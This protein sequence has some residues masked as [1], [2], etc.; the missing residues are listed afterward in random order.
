MVLDCMYD[1]Q[2][3]H[4]INS[5]CITNAQTFYDIVTLSKL[6]PPD[7]IRFKTV[8]SA[9][10]NDENDF[11]FVC[12]HMTCAV[13]DKIF[14][15]SENTASLK[16]SVYTTNLATLF[17]AFG[18]ETMKHFDLRRGLSEFVDMQECEKEMNNGE[19]VISDRTIS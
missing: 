9:G 19:F 14:D 6:I 10:V 13:G 1:Y 3:Q 2:K 18:K 16:N 17:A 12:N 11:G 5:K 15:P 4:N 7:K 8:M